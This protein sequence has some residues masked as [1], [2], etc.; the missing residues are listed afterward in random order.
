MGDF[1]SRTG[2]ANDIMMIESQDNIL[3]ASNFTYP[4]IINILNSL[5]MPITRV[6]KDTKTNNNGKRLIEMCKLQELCILNGRAG[7]DR[8]IGNLTFDYKSTIDY[9][10]CTPDLL[11][12][13]SHCEVDTLDYTISD[14]HN[15]IQ[16]SINVEGNI[17]REDRPLEETEIP[18]KESIT[19]CKWND[20]KKDEYQMS[21]DERKI[22]NI[23]DIVAAFNVTETTQDSMDSIANDLKDIFLEP[24]KATGMFTKCNINKN[25]RRRICNKPWFNNEC[26][27]SKKRL[28]EI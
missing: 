22:N 27:T 14:K 7:L 3:D 8:N 16:L 18:A 25:K 1:N 20:S 24:A 5:G 13:I 26:D 6:N 12:K 19:K 21:F 11:H 15:P 10:I 9:M 2:N 28:Q 17:T 23:S 4:N